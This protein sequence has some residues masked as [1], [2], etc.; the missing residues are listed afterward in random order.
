MLKSAISTLGLVSSMALF[1]ELQSA[2]SPNDSEG[3]EF[4]AGLIKDLTLKMKD[5]K[6]K[7]KILNNSPADGG[8]SDYSMLMVRLVILEYPYFWQSCANLS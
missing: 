3:Q 8:F 1:K 7:Q 2:I 6:A 5:L 4:M